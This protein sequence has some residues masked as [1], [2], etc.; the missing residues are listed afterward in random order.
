MK[1]TC[2]I[3]IIATIVFSFFACAKKENGLFQITYKVTFLSENAE[4]IFIA[5]REAI[6]YK[7]LYIDKD[8]SKD[9]LLPNDAL[10]SLLAIPQANTR[11][12][13]KN[14][15]IWEQTGGKERIM[16]SGQIIKKNKAITSYGTF[17][18]ITSFIS[19]I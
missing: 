9:V 15:E 2:K 13:T 7:T 16:I 11:I 4:P 14:Y 1:T 12:N 3:L 6:G 10:V 8:W 5:Y 17:I 18:E 19:D